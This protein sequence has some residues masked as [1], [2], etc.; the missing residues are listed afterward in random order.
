MTANT[1]RFIHFTLGTTAKPYTT[2]FYKMSDHTGKTS[3]TALHDGMAYLE[4]TIR[5]RDLEPVELVCDD[6]LPVLKTLF[7]ALL[8]NGQK[9]E[10]QQDD[11]IYLELGGEDPKVLYF[12]R[13]QIL[14]IE[15]NRPVSEEMVLAS[16]VADAVSHLLPRP[17]SPFDDSWKYWIWSNV[18]QGCAKARIFNILLENGFGVEDIRFELGYEPSLEVNHP[19]ANIQAAA[20]EWDRR[21]T[22]SALVPLPVD[23]IE[24]YEITEFLS[25]SECEKLISMMNNSYTRST[26]S[27]ED[28]ANGAIDES[29]T[30]SSTYFD[31]S[32]PFIQTIEQKIANTIGIDI[33][34]GEAMQ[35]QQYQVGDFFKAHHDYFDKNN[36]NI[37]QN[38]C[39]DGDR[40]WTVLVYLNEEGLEGGETYFP[41]LSLV[42]KPA[43]G[44]ALC[45]RNM[46]PD[47]SLNSNTLHAG[48]PPITG[49]KYIIT[50]WFR[51]KPTEE[52]GKAD[53][54]YFSTIND[55]PRLDKNGVGFEKRK[56]PKHI[57]A[58]VEEA[59]DGLKPKLEQ[60]HW[61]NLT[62]YIQDGKGN[63]PCDI[64]SF[65]HFPELRDKIH[66][67]LQ[68][69]VQ[70]W[71]GDEYPITATDLYGIR[72]YKRGAM[73]KMHSDRVETHHV[74]CVVVVDK[75]VDQDWPLHCVDDKG[76]TQKIYL[77]PGEF[78]LYEC[79]K[80]I[81][82]RPE[83]LMGDWYRN[84]F[85]HYK[86]D[87][88]KYRE[89]ATALTE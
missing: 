50:K 46:N 29:R 75:K 30:S 47:G 14:T 89:A 62:D 52:Y 31:R 43:V 82:G 8:A 23:E 3:E 48:L 72:S 70:E 44:K 6:D 28:V 57:L 80:T 34:Y 1:S 76:E 69:I 4:L 18:N 42:V 15:T 24:A 32:D 16:D 78:V 68:T 65:D 25:P 54:K 66:K 81:H 33:K 51:E 26:V 59:Y 61:D 56:L 17:H 55:L 53:K 35:G 21:C 7:Q 19:L 12:L 74:G 84:F 85:V 22:D 60:E 45:W 41:S 37:Y 36:E 71:I 64:M 88:W 5:F 63:N 58:M 13:S 38:Y 27:A 20:P 83:P 2:G 9:N 40:T 49:T 79:A 87:N 11:L 73:L 86:L 39:Q 77:E 10:D 67:E